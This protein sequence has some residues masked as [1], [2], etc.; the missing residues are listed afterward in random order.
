MVVNIYYLPVEGIGHDPYDY[1]DV[2]VVVVGWSVGRTSLSAVICSYAI[3]F[4]V[5]EAPIHVFVRV[6]QQRK[7]EIASA[8]GDW[9]LGSNGLP[10]SFGG[11]LF[12]YV[13][14]SEGTAA[15]DRL[16]DTSLSWKHRLSDRRC[17]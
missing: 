6:K 12:C 17:S 9:F 5:F 11:R 2:V 8:W 16:V 14:F 13:A 7:R 3:S 4:F 1:L 10:T 15:T